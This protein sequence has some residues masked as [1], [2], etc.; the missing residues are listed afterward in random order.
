[1]LLRYAYCFTRCNVLI[2]KDKG[3]RL[4]VVDGM[5]GVR[6][7]VQSCPLCVPG[8]GRGQ[9]AEQ[10]KGEERRELVAVQRAAGGS[11]ARKNVA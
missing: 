4:P 2:K 3:G 5:S 7:S 9:S 1:M 10:L 8:S 6:S 11:S